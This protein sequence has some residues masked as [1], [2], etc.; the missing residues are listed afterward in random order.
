MVLHGVLL[1]ALPDL[2]LLFRQVHAEYPVPAF[3]PTCLCTL[4]AAENSPAAILTG[5]SPPDLPLRAFQI[6]DE[7]GIRQMVLQSPCLGCFQ[8]APERSCQAS[9]ETVAV[10][11]D[12]A[13][14]LGVAVLED[15]ERRLSR[16]DG[17]LRLDIST[18]G[19]APPTTVAKP[20]GTKSA[21][22]K[23]A[24]DLG[25]TTRPGLA[26][27]SGPVWRMRS[28]VAWKAVLRIAKRRIQNGRRHR[29]IGHGSVL[30]G[31]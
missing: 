16:A 23:R 29:C 15:G 2:P 3:T 24:I 1:E 18:R 13:E 30:C 9:A 20:L 14:T 11:T 17:L 31:P 22:P 8:A 25:M 27:G 26:L 12:L 7:L 4:L 5:H 10:G 21:H 28:A 6:S 19:Q